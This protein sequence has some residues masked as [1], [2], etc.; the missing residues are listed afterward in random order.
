VVEPES[1]R[2]VDKYGRA[3]KGSQLQIQIYVNRRRDELDRAAL[4]ALPSLAIWSP[5]L[6]W[7]SPLEDHLFKEYYDKEFLTSVGLGA[8]APLL[9]RFWPA[10]GP[11]WDALAVIERL[12]APPGVLLVEAKSYAGE[13]RG[14]G[15][16]ASSGKS[17][18]R[19]ARALTAT[20]DWLEVPA[21]ARDAWTGN[22]YQTANRLAHL[23]WLRQIAGVDA[24]LLHVLF[25]GDKSN[26]PTPEKEWTEA[27]EQAD[28]ELGLEPGLVPHAWHAILPARK[29]EEL[30]LTLA[31]SSAKT[32]AR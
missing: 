23:F 26:R 1:K 30:T 8:L 6:R 10:R 4:R 9:R 5:R 28:S 15:I 13:L 3:E 29:R 31:E 17:R 20:Q 24:W 27:I 18:H 7:V 2:R 25:T 12:S 16:S 22:L 14:T 19:I 11:H 32:G 21:G